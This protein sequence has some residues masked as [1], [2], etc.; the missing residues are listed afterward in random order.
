MTNGGETTH[1]AVT[2]DV[3]RGSGLVASRQ[4]ESACGIGFVKEVEER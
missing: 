2:E 3:D 4:D 1:R